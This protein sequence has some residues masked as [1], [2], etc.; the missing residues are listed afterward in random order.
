MHNQIF[1]I[2]AWL[3]AKILLSLMSQPPIVLGM[4]HSSLGWVFKKRLI[5]LLFLVC[6]FIILGWPILPFLLYIWLNLPS[7]LYA[8]AFSCIDHCQSSSIGIDI[9]SLFQFHS[10]ISCDAIIRKQSFLVWRTSVPTTAAC[11][12]QCMPQ[13]VWNTF[14]SWFALMTVYNKINEGIDRW[15]QF[16][17]ILSLHPQKQTVDSTSLLFF[18]FSHCLPKKLTTKSGWQLRYLHWSIPNFH[19][20]SDQGSCF[21]C[22]HQA[23]I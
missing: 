9:L 1:Q 12:G 8:K 7:I 5:F 11:S 21:H 19:M 2:Q 22:F 17:N 15:L 6:F 13:V 14:W 10:F 3:T 4:S 18:S 23:T 20:A 16:A